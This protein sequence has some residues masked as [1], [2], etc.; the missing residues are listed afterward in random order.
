MKDFQD[1]VA[2]I[3]GAGNGFG[4][5]FAKE[6]HRRGMK[7]MLVDIDEH[8]VKRT[9]SAILDDRGVAEFCVADVSLES[10]VDRMVK[11]TLAAFG[12]IDLLINNAGVAIGGSVVNMPTRDWEWIV[13]VNDMSQ[14][15]AMKRV[16]PIMT[17]QDSPC[18]IVNVASLAGLVT[19]GSMPA[20]F[21]TKHFSVALTESANYDLQAKNSK[22]GMSV[23]CPGYVQTDLF[24]YERHRPERFK[25]PND[26]YYAS[27][28]YKEILKMAER[29]IT[30]GIPLD[31]IAA[32]VFR[33]IEL[34]D[35]YIETNKKAKWLIFDRARNIIF[36][37]N[38]N[39]AKV[40]AKATK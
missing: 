19:M 30:T 37:K 23:F 24:N 35:F 36:Q 33:A 8:D 28:A 26:P 11:A 10:E 20:Y 27:D 1:K 16:I 15:Y 5:D 6:A 40:M 25:A 7:L 21:A 39:Y 34:G 17:A 38:P 13:A 2:L 31:P 4:A 3:T 18:H 14:I 9:Q 12:R 32:L 29:V 22:I